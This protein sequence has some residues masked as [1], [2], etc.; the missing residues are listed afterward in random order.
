MSGEDDVK[1]IIPM[2]S[3]KEIEAA[4]NIF[5]SQKKT[6]REIYIE[7]NVGLESIYT[8]QKLLN[9]KKLLDFVQYDKTKENG[10]P[11]RAVEYGDKFLLLDGNHRVATAIL[12]KGKRL[13]IAVLNP[14][15]KK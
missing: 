4:M 10:E 14:V 8:M 9:R 6:G 7:K 12:K 3:K 15:E 5:E 2:A 1:N 11:I 13:K